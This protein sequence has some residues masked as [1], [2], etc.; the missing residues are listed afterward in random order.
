MTTY[1]FTFIVDADPHAEDFEDRFIEAGCDDA[2]FILV[3]GAAALSF[4]R[5]AAS[6]KEAVLSAFRDI[7]KPVPRSFGLSRTS[8]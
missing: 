4:D 6:Y 7:R 8:S 2:T 3:R 5:D 1:D